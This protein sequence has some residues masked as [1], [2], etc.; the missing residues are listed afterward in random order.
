[1]KKSTSQRRVPRKIGGE[2][3]D[4][5]PM[6][7]ST[8]SGSAPTESA[9][10]R[11][12][13][14]R[15]STNLRKSFGPS[16]LQT[17]EDDTADSDPASVITPKR[18]TLSKIAVQRNAS[19]RSSFQPSDL[20]SEE[21]ADNAPTY[22]AADLQAL[23]ASTPSTPQNPPSDTD[24]VTANTQALDL[25]SKFGS[26]LAR[27]QASAQ[28]RPSAIP[29]ATE[30]AE[31]KARRAR[32]AL[33][34]Q[35]DEFVSLDPDEP[36]FDED[37]D[38]NVARDESGRLILRPKD[39]YGAA[40]SRLARDDEDVMEGFDEFTGETGARVRMDESTRGG[41]RE[42]RKAEMAERIAAAEAEEAGSESGDESERERNEAFEAAQTRHGAYGAGAGAAGRG[43]EE[44]RPRTPPKIAPLPSLEG[45]IARLRAQLEGMQ[46]ARMER[47][48]E[49]EALAREKVRI[50]EEEV[51]VQKALR[52]TGEKFEALRREKGIASG[53]ATKE[54]TPALLEAGRGLGFLG[55]GG[56]G[57]DGEDEERPR[58]GLGM[59][60]RGLESLGASGA[61]TPVGDSSDQAMDDRTT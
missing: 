55:N 26:S 21:P 10:K 27:Y 9:I 46:T 2:D 60:G 11:P 4:D 35:A 31:K 19:A 58:L 17:D 56:A 47:V 42:R 33:E 30:I 1:M 49:M 54:G 13:K 40:E 61:G 44:G 23:R 57:E 6:G 3:D 34:A 32:L 39:K 41:E 8:G 45:V 22:S 48:G 7:N 5:E 53:A 51:R 12:N 20:P 50:G 59:A 16:A 25:N 15:K 37:E 43:E 52:E 28:Q 36:G 18:S 24:S 38:G 29:S 14:P